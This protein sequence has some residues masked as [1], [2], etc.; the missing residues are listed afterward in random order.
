MEVTGAIP[1]VSTVPR[2][3]SGAGEQILTRQMFRLGQLLHLPE[4]FLGEVWRNKF[5]LPVL[6][7]NAAV[8]DCL[9]NVDGSWFPWLFW[10]S[11][12][13]S[14]GRWEAKTN[15]HCASRAP[16]FVGA[17]IERCLNHGKR[18]FHHN[19][20]S[21]VWSSRWRCGLRLTTWD[22]KKDGMNIL[23]QYLSARISDFSS[24]E[25]VHLCSQV[26]WSSDFRCHPF[27]GGLGDAQ[28]AS[29]EKVDLQRFQHLPRF[30][31]WHPTHLG[32]PRLTF[33]YAH[34]GFYVT[35]G[36]VSA[37]MPILAPWEAWCVYLSIYLSPQ[38]TRMVDESWLADILR[39]LSLSFGWLQ[40]PLG[41]IHWF[42]GIPLASAMIPGDFF[43]VSDNVDSLVDEPQKNR[44]Q[45]TGGFC[46]DSGE[47]KETAPMLAGFPGDWSRDIFWSPNVGEPFFKGSRSGIPKKV[48]KNCQ[49]P[50]GFFMIFLGGSTTK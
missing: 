46:L 3:S 37:S 18:A 32:Q 14:V 36:L 34:V 6:I 50:F 27:F 42:I 30:F 21:Q 19:V 24:Q 28:R 8:M 13:W 33:Y 1:W 11:S 16:V 4:A 40:L 38:P 7:M 25:Y 35:Q 43:H 15:G 22:V 26:D 9:W 29:Q 10:L 31:W 5:C 23:Y 17:F 48:T 49:I 47:L 20:E 44:T 12:L 2:L 45:K 39:I 41:G